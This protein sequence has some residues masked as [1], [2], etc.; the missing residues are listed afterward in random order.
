MRFLRGCRNGRKF[1][2]GIV[3]LRFGRLVP[4]VILGRKVHVKSIL[5]L[6]LTIRRKVVRLRIFRLSVW[7][8]V[9]NGSARRSRRS[10]GTIEFVVRR[11]RGLRVIVITKPLWS[12]ILVKVWFVRLSIVFVFG[13]NKR[14]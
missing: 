10:K 2:A 8:V 12:R 3:S 4:C 6:V 5:L 1:I 13:Q 11:S 14:P 9:R 7:I